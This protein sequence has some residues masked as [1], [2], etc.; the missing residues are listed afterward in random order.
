MAS[1]GDLLVH[2]GLAALRPQTLVPRQTFD[3]LKEDAQMAR[4]R[5][6]VTAE[7]G[8]N[9]DATAPSPE[10]EQ[11]RSQIE[12]TRAGMSQTIDAIQARLGPAR[13]ATE[14]AETVKE[15]TVGRVK[16]LANRI[17]SALRGGS[18]GGLDAERALAAVTKNPVPAVILGVAATAIVARTLSRSRSGSPAF[19]ADRYRHSVGRQ[20]LIGTCAGVACWGVWKTRKPKPGPEEI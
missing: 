19:R 1:A 17:H 8:S 5:D 4:E 6:K 2:A 15:A 18:G 11:I 7:P 14:A 13:V 10:T 16:N 9:E 12:Q 3:T 20:L